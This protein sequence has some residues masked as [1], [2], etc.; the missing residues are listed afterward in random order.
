[1]QGFCY[2]SGTTT[3]PFILSSVVVFKMLEKTEAQ[4]SLEFDLKIYSFAD[5]H[6]I[7]FWKRVAKAVKRQ[8]EHSV[9]RDDLRT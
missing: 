6:V 8:E 9:F 7:G 4:E 1:M 5:V 2:S 3:K